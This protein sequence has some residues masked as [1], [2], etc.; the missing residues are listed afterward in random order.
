MS[1]RALVTTW[2]ALLGLAAMSF[3]FSYLHIG[4]WGVPVALAIA[5]M[6]VALVLLVFMELAHEGA[7]VRMAMITATVL[8][9]VLLVLV[10]MDR[11]ARRDVRVSD[12]TQQ[13][14]P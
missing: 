2:L 3:G 6:K 7:S 14:S 4:S 8:I 13:T 9:A 10:L 5:A 11:A 1:T 12:G